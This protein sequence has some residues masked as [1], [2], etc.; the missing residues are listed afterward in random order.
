MRGAVAGAS[1]DAATV[2][3]P[4]ARE[5][6]AAR[7]LANIRLRLVSPLVGAVAATLKCPS[8][9]TGAC[10]PNGLCKPCEA[11]LRG[12]VQSPPAP[13]GDAVWLGPH[14]GIWRRLVHALK[15]RDARRLAGF[16][17]ELLHLRTTLWSWQPSVVTHLPT[18]RQRRRQR[19]Y[20]QAELL[21]VAL[22]ERS[23]LPY[24]NALER[25]GAGTTLA[26]QGRA[27]RAASLAQA[28]TAKA[29]AGCK[30]LLVDDVM[31]TGASLASARAALLAAG[32]A[33]VRAAFVA[34]TA[35]R[36]LDGAVLTA[37]L[38]RLE[39][40]PA[41]PASHSERYDQAG[42]HAQKGAHDHLWV[43]VPE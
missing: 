25:H 20:D 40:P 12:A 43:R 34:R 24:R 42:S 13:H 39:P 10:G 33:E 41:E 21:A 29:V 38:A 36:S 4:T 2:N 15:Y 17:A 26:G 16:L 14:A 5:L 31:T 18:T 28:F 6:T 11:L 9:T 23:G 27:A 30:V 22:A 35:P 3:A 1:R 19:S 8:C 7:L 32:A 37:A